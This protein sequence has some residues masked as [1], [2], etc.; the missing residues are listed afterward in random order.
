MKER[1]ETFTS[2]RV[3][4][5]TFPTLPFVHRFLE[6]SKD[7]FLFH[8]SVVSRFPHG[9]ET[10]NETPRFRNESMFHATLLHDG[11]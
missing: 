3:V 1:K 2:S 8:E 7:G 6:P 10:F 5:L 11:D 9:N 4:A